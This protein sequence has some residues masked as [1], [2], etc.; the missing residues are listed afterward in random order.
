MLVIMAAGK[1]TRMGLPEGVNKCSLP[2][3][4]NKFDTSVNRLIKQFNQT[5]NVVVVGY[6]AESVTDSID[7]GY[8]SSSSLTKIHI[9][10]NPLATNFGSGYTLYCAKEY[11]KNYC[12][13]GDDPVCYFAEGDSVYSDEVVNKFMCS[14]DSSVLV[15]SPCYLSN[16]S[17]AVLDRFCQVQSMIYDTSHKFNFQELS[18]IQCKDGIEVSESM[19]LWKICGTRAKKSFVDK[20]TRDPRGTN[21][22]PFLEIASEGL[23]KTCYISDEFSEGW[24]NLN[25][26]EDYEKTKQLIQEGKL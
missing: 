10:H 22:S 20:L 13:E 4:E 1:G 14:R 9:V 2:L 23:F 21:L 24:A 12:I 15:R 6:G 11:I 3:S 7:L 5:V 26:K 17:V 18:K 16:R 19:Q 25:T 8:L